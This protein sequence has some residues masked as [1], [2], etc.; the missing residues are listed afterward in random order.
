MARAARIIPR[1]GSTSRDQTKQLRVERALARSNSRQ[2][3]LTKHT[4]T[5]RDYIR[6]MQAQARVVVE[7][8]R[9]KV[10]LNEEGDLVIDKGLIQTAQPDGL[11]LRGKVQQTFMRSGGDPNAHLNSF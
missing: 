4:T 1:S 10:S 7:Y 5:A 3:Q 2:Q 6:K 9:K 8:T 11:S